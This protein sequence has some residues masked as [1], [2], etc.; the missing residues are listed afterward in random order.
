GALGVGGRAVGDPRQDHSGRRVLDLV[1][2]AAGHEAG[3][4]H[5]HPYG[6]SLAVALRQRGVD[7]DHGLAP[8]WSAGASAPAAW[9]GGQLASLSEM[10]LTSAGHSIAKRGS[11]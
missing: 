1:G 5:R 3:G 11:S 4:D 6:T 8:G 9:K 2:H 10:T 7:D